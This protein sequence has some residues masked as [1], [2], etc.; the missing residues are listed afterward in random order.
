M[1]KKTVTIDTAKLIVIYSN[2]LKREFPLTPNRE[3]AEGKKYS[4]DRIGFEPKSK[5]LT[6]RQGIYLDKPKPTAKGKK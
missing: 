1:N 5:I 6:S 2:G 4:F 3:E